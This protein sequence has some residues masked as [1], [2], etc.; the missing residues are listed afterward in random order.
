MPAP[1]ACFAGRTTQER[2]SARR[3]PDGCDRV[4][5]RGAGEGF[6]VHICTG[7]V[8]VKD[9]QPGDVLEVRI[10]DIVPR[11]EPQSRFRG[12]GVRQQRRGVVGLSLQ[13]VARRAE[14]A[15][16]GD[17]LRDLRPRRRCRMRAR[18]IPIAGSRR[19]IRSAWST[20]PTT[21]RACRSRPGSVKRRHDVLDGIRIPLRP[22]FGV[23]AVAPREVGFRRFDSA[24]LFRRQPRQLA[25]RQGIDGLSAGFG[26]RRVAVGRRSPC[27][28]GRRRTGRHRD[29]MLDDRNVPAHPAQEGRSGRPRRSPTSPIP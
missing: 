27:D 29:R 26:A 23:I 11:A 9:A 19:P 15:R 13:R 3:R 25:A 14:T 22:H 20:R 24:V 1:R 12:P 16:G 6:G 18:S 8:A 28:P 4:Y 7:P 21:I 17:D 2:R 10:L 5:G